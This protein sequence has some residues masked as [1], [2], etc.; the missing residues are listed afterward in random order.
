MGNGDNNFF[1]V[2]IFH[3]S[4]MRS[5]PSPQTISKRTSQNRSKKSNQEIDIFRG[6]NHKKHTVKNENLFSKEQQKNLNRTSHGGTL[7]QGKRKTAR[8]LAP[9]KF[10]HAVLKSEKAVLTRYQAV[11]SSYLQKYAKKNFVE[12]SG[13]QVM[14]N[15]IHFRFRF[16]RKDLYKNFIRAATG[17]I[18]SYMIKKVKCA[19]HFWT[20]TLFTRV[21]KTSFE[22]WFCRIICT[23]MR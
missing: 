14:G 18:A 15:H 2:P 6:K 8:P 21:L 13:L 11:I 23:Q 10:H 19:S 16:K 12:I 20:E 4:S 9:N 1:V 17:Q 22:N 7:S 5:T 3:R